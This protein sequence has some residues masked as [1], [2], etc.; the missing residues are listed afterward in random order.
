L[1]EKYV[2]DV[3][4]DGY[5]SNITEEMN[6]T[7]KNTYNGTSVRQSLNEYLVDYMGKPMLELLR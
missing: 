3:L 7:W 2:K 5:F 6:T 4:D 1:E